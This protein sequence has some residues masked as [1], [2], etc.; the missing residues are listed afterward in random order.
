MEWIRGLSQ[1]DAAGLFAHT[2]S[3]VSGFAYV[4]Y[5]LPPMGDGTLLPSDR[6]YVLPCAYSRDDANFY[7]EGTVGD[8]IRL[9]S[10]VHEYQVPVVQQNAFLLFA[11]TIGFTVLNTVVMQRRVPSSEAMLLAGMEVSAVCCTRRKGGGGGAPKTS[12]NMEGKSI[13]LW[14]EVVGVSNLQVATAGLEEPLLEVRCLSADPRRAPGALLEAGADAEARTRPLPGGTDSPEWRESLFLPVRFSKAGFVQLVLREAGAGGQQDIALAHAA[15]PFSQALRFNR[16][17]FSEQRLKLQVL[18]GGQRPGLS[19]A[20]VQVRF[21]CLEVSEL[22]RLRKRV[23]DEMDDGKFKLQY[24]EH[25]L[26]AL[27]HMQ[28]AI[29]ADGSAG[30]LPGVGEAPAA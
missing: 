4:L 1:R 18:G 8:C 26:E 7:A 17:D 14:C 2:A 16:R 20:T 11:A 6:P 25:Q 15:L 30:A 13:I 5:F 21:R 19:R 3:F 12:S 9:F 10:V 27:Q 24:F 28:E 29:A 23:K 22:V